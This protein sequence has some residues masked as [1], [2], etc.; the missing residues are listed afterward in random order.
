MPTLILWGE[1]DPLI[2]VAH[3]HSAHQTIQGSR[4]EIFQ[5]AGHFPYRDNPQRFMNVLIDFI[6]STA[7]AE[8]NE[9]RWWESGGTG[10]LRQ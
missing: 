8:V 4:L 3:A 1:H 9:Q 10:T 2:P 7:P 6:Q 5:R